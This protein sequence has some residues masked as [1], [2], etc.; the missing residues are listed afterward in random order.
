MPFSSPPTL[1]QIL[2]DAFWSG[3]FFPFAEEMQ[4]VENVQ[5]VRVV[6]KLRKYQA[7]KQ[8]NNPFKKLA[9][10]VAT[11]YKTPRVVK[12]YVDAEGPRAM[13]LDAVDHANIVSNPSLNNFLAAEEGA[14]SLLRIDILPKFLNSRRFAVAKKY[15][16]PMSQ[17]PEVWSEP[18]PLY[19]QT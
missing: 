11:A 9:G 4:A 15:A 1:E 18:S 17:I 16:P 19:Q 2:D 6:E 14:Y 3:Q 13:N 8:S 12:K 5:F 10:T 7:L